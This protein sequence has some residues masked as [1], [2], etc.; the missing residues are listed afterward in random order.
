M[1]A[2]RPYA[3]QDGTV[4]TNGDVGDSW[5]LIAAVHIY[6]QAAYFRLFVTSDRMPS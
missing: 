5:K 1:R 4:E 6:P 3:L 2:D